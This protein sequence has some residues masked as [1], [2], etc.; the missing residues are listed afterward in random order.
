MI[1]W[2]VVSSTAVVVSSLNPSPP[3]VPCDTKNGCLGDK[4]P[5]RRK[6][7]WK[8]AFSVAEYKS[9]VTSLLNWMVYYMKK[10]KIKELYEV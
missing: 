1:T 4:L 5:C 10:K 9:D 7:A 3:L 2:I 8:N 6:C